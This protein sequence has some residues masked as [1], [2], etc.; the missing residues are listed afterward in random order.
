VSPDDWHDAV[1]VISRGFFPVRYLHYARYRWAE[2]LAAGGD[3]DEAAEV[4]ASVVAIAPAQGASI[5]AR[6]A[7]ELAARCG[8]PLDGVDA[9]SSASSASGME[10]LTPR[11]LQV[12]ELVA[13]GLTNPQIGTRLFISPKTVSVHVSAILAKI[14]ATNRAE[15]A[16]LYA[17]AQPADELS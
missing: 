6:W 8:I 1:E 16:A 9:T 10:A 11:E 7:R 12:L 2:A 17:S 13:E 5:V 15:A 14:G 3:R 4:L